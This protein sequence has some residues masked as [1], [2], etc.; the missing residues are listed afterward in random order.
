VH[1][2]VRVLGEPA[3]IERAVVRLLELARLVLAPV[4]RSKVWAWD[5]VQWRTRKDDSVGPIEKER[6]KRAPAVGSAR[7][8]GGVVERG[9]KVEHGGRKG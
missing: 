2:D 8:S 7:A 9:R 5:S 6:A 3:R 4:F 1:E